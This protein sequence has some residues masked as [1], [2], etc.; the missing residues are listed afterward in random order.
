MGV[1]IGHDGTRA[2][3]SVTSNQWWLGEIELV[4]RLRA[5]R[6]DVS[7]LTHS[8]ELPTVDRDAPWRTGELIALLTHFCTDRLAL[9]KQ[10]EED[11]A[12]GLIA[13]ILGLEQLAIDWHVHCVATRGNRLTD[14][15]AAL[16][17]LRGVHDTPALMDAACQELVLG[18]GFHRA[19]LS[20]VEPQGWKPQI[21]H[22]RSGLGAAS[23]FGAWKNRTVPFTEAAPEVQILSHRRASLIY[24]TSEETVYQPFIVQAGQS[25]SYVSAPL[26]LGR[27]VIGFLHSD[28]FPLTRRVDVADRDV[29]A[30]FAYGFSL[31]YDCLLAAQRAREYRDAVRDLMAD[32]VDR[33][34]GL[35]DSTL[36][37][38]EWSTADTAAALPARRPDSAESH[39]ARLTLRQSEVLDLMVR[40]LGNR[41]IARELVITEE[42]VK[43]H[44]QR[45]LRAYSVPSRAQVIALAL[46]RT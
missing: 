20:K 32:V 1:S 33:I 14:C 37:M 12:H 5:V 34:D 19:A 27:D 15:A 36:A 31:L 23:W 45:I 13:M 9:V 18:C 39:R 21:I 8:S 35:C 24:D 17:R 11:D 7:A 43:S 44:V 41:Q 3:V 22:D 4:E 25:R 46:R 16:S 28:H 38:R 42:T 29:M 10:T 26:T 40:G 30:A 2:S 6:D